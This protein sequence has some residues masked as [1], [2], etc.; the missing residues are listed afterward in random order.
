MNRQE[1]LERL[2][3]G[4]DPLELSIQ[5]WQDIVDGKGQDEGDLNCA[6]CE[7][8]S[9]K[10]CEGCP[11]REKTGKSDCADTP[12]FGYQDKMT[13]PAKLRWAKKELEFLKSL[14]KKAEA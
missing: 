3:K 5:K 2:A 10:D 1:M 9:P 11:I 14:R 7:E 4:E 13:K 6:L 8:Y 12:Y